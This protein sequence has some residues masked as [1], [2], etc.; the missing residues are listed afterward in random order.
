KAEAAS[1]RAGRSI[2]TRIAR[3]YG[4]DRHIRAGT[5][6]LVDRGAERIDGVVE[7]RRQDGNIA[8]EWSGQATPRVHRATQPRNGREPER[9]R[10]LVRVTR[11][12]SPLGCPPG[13]KRARAGG[14]RTR[15]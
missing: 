5:G 11:T 7:M 8:P 2:R 10:P 14:G 9:R 12:A 15:R 1:P 4:D 13:A 6:T 3:E